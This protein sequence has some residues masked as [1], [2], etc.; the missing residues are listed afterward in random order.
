MIEEIQGKLRAPTVKSVMQNEAMYK[1]TR[2]QER[3]LL[4][5]NP[6][7]KRSQ[8]SFANRGWSREKEKSNQDILLCL[9]EARQ[10]N[11]KKGDSQDPF[12]GMIGSE[13]GSKSHSRH[14]PRKPLTSESPRPKLP[15]NRA[16]QF[17]QRPQTKHLILNQ[18]SRSNVVSF[19]ENKNKNEDVCISIEV[20]NSGREEG[21]KILGKSV[22]ESVV[23]KKLT[24]V[25]KRIMK[26]ERMKEARVRV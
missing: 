2:P 5:F 19:R 3:G 6:S 25:Q 10:R 17:R 16:V 22:I 15:A 11:L 7:L 4:P 12:K 9:V 21:S 18:A 14:S 13:H 1:I 8:D 26:E 20:P 23:N 24:E